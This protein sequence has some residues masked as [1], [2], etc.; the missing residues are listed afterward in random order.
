VSPAPRVD[1]AGMWEAAC[2]WPEQLPDVLEAAHRLFGPSIGGADKPVRAVV[3]F[4][5]GTGGAACD[6]AAALTAGQLGVPFVVC[7][8]AA[9]PAFVG[10]DCLVV[11]MACGDTPE[12]VAAARESEAR[13]AHVVGIG[14]DVALAQLVAGFG[15]P[16]CDVGALGPASR[17]AFGPATVSL[18]GLLSAAGLAP[19]RAAE[20][21]AAA[22]LVARRRDAFVADRGN[23]AELA[24]R[25][26][27]TIPLVYGS[28]GIAAV[29]ARWWK[30]CVNLNA[31]AAAFA[32][33]LP[34]LAYD[35]V[36]GWGQGGDITRQ[37]MTLV[38]LRH[39]GE[40]SAVPVLFASVRA[41]TE[42]VMA[43]VLDVWADSPDDLGRLLELALLGE[44]VSLE[45]A[46]REGVD[47]GPVPA[48]EEAHFAQR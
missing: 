28:N 32:A 47:P 21:E 30:S 42:E 37:T 13:G 34:G 14:N 9:V 4:G 38:F 2:A 15:S 43:D 20:V 39:Q 3:G 22:E 35:E 46:A 24:R 1:S 27:R 33:E 31:K 11:A 44:L 7:H 17:G 41:A 29:T 10:P 36:A 18:L 26:G 16:W 6:A 48:V 45:M 5:V 8:D 23:A 25:I 12:T 19:D 40:P